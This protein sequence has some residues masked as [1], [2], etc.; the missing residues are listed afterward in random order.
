MI[1]NKRNG[2]VESITDALSPLNILKKLLFMIAVVGIL[3]IRELIYYLNL[4]G[5]GDLTWYGAIFR[6]Y[7]D[8]LGIIFSS[9]WSF[10]ISFTSEILGLGD[11]FFG[12]LFFLGAL[13]VVYQ[14]VSLI[15]D[16][17]DF[18]KGHNTNLVFRIMVS[19]LI[20]IILSAII[21]YSGAESIIGQN[22]SL[23]N[24]TINSTINVTT[25]VTNSTGG[26]ITLK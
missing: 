16:A 2:F 1:E 8:G 21:Y 5:S 19:L 14:P 25:N 3:S 17:L 11:W 15:I 26:I 18:K 12:I 7:Y 9:V 6:A 24:E 23:V 10:F 13:Y 4:A 22:P 20:V